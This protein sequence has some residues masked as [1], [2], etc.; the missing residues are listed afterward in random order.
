MAYDR[1]GNRSSTFAGLIDASSIYG[2]SR[3]AAR[4]RVDTLVQSIHDNWAEAADAGRLTEADRGR[5]WGRQ[6]LNP[7]AM[8]GLGTRPPATRRAEPSPA[9]QAPAR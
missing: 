5:L 4:E 9:A 3:D 7:A 6:I 8:Y 2:L 1:A